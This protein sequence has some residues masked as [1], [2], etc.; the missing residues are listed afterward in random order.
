MC[1]RDS[2]DPW[3]CVGCSGGTTP[4][5]FYNGINN[6]NEGFPYYGSTVY[7]SLSPYGIYDMCGNIGEW[8]DDLGSDN[9]IYDY[10][11]GSGYSSSSTEEIKVF[12][13]AELNCY[14]TTK[15]IGFRVVQRELFSII[16]D[17]INVK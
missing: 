17:T 4:V 1:I 7:N 15:S 13:L 11:S 6:L 10:R 16:I 14:K 12:A 5:G 2:Y 3:D 9:G 8:T